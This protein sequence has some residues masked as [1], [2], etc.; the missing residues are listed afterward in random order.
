[1]QIPAAR[2]RFPEEDR[3][4]LL[5]QIDGILATGQLTLGKYTKEF[6]TAFAAYVGTKYAVAVNS[7]TSALEIILRA[8]HLR[9][10]EI[11]LPTNT[12]AAT[13][14]GVL[15]SGNDVILAD[16]DDDL[17]LDPE[18]V[19]RQWR[20]ERGDKVPTEPAVVAPKAV[21]ETPRPLT[22]SPS[23]VVAALMTVG[24]VVFGIYLASQ[25]M[26]FAKPPTLELVSPASAVPRWSP[27]RPV[28]SRQRNFTSCCR[29]TRAS[30]E[31]HCAREGPPSRPTCVPILG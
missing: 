14:F 21:L 9:G 1:M 11:V 5:E 15:H 29:L 12:F 27:R 18:D 20:R 8:L 2:I 25:L 22:F 30:R 4:Q 26:R 23:I 24:V 10:G 6:E 13:A 28:N 17:N 16:V 7:G 19:L 31:S 3:K